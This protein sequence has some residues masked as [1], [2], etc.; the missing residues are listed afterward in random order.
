MPGKKPLTP[1][2]IKAKIKKAQIAARK[3]HM[4]VLSSAAKIRVLNKSKEEN[5][6]KQMKKDFFP[7]AEPKTKT[8]LG[9][10]NTAHIS[11]SGTEGIKTD[12]EKQ[13]EREAAAA[14]KGK[15]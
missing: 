12:L 13:A 6:I 9:G 14:K 8:L 4:R 3:S 7:E 1:T 10:Q 2:E 5:P 11:R 15:K